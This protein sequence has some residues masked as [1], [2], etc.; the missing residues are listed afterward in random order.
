VTATEDR[1]RGHAIELVEG[2]WVYADDGQP[3]AG[4]VR[5]C[6]HC[7]AKD[8]AE[9]HDGC[10]GTVPGAVNACCGH[11]DEGAAYVQF[12]PTSSVRREAALRW[13]RP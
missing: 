5:P 10:L 11:G 12:S 9:G 13:A 2:A 7:G 6:G 1:L 8:T 3:T 4:N